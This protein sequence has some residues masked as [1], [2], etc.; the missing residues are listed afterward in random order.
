M[1]QQIQAIAKQFYGN[2]TDANFEKLY[3]VLQPI[4]YN[5]SSKVL[6]NHDDIEENVSIVLTKIYKSTNF[7]FDENKSY[8]SYAYTVALNS[9]KMLFNKLKN[10]KLVCES[11]LSPSGEEAR[12]NILDYIYI[13]GG[14][15]LDPVE[16]DEYYLHNSVDFQFEKV[17]ELIG[18]IDKD[19]QSINTSQIIMDALCND[20]VLSSLR[21]L[22]GLVDEE[23]RNSILALYEE[24][25]GD[26]KP[27]KRRYS[28]IAAEFG[29]E[30]GIVKHVIGIRDMMMNEIRHYGTIARQ[31]GMIV[32]EHLM[33]YEQVAEK[34]GLNT[35]GAV[36]TKV[37]R[38]KK[39]IKNKLMSEVRKS[40]RADGKTI[41]GNEKGYFE[42]CRQ[43]K[44]EINWLNGQKH[45]GW[46]TFFKN[47]NKKI[48]T[49]YANDK[50]HGKHVEFY[51]NGI[52]KITGEYVDGKKVGIW[53]GLNMDETV[54][55][56]YDYCGD[57]IRFIHY[58]KHGNI[59][60][61]GII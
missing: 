44:Y 2:K 39:H 59:E 42:D 4:I 46:A 19:S 52:A 6:R 36:K 33:T 3:E 30:K 8:L 32:P 49:S 61:H 37:F 51:E 50:Y 56:K 31:Y 53:I 60:D 38:A 15:M 18:E 10:N 21:K 11:S 55:S 35:I 28:I 34:H 5:L 26:V 17:I 40:Q 23:T 20:M 58:D 16:C 12:D 29:L 41:T 48:E 13:N 45:G 22:E 47:G 27:K 43:L 25:K 14:N 57:G 1:S 24:I 54:D 9:A 7:V